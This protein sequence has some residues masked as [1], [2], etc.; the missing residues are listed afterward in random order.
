MGIRSFAVLDGPGALW[1]STGTAATTHPFTGFGG[2]EPGEASDFITFDPNLDV[3]GSLDGGLVPGD[4]T[5][6]VARDAGGQTN[7]WFS[8]GTGAGTH[9]IIGVLGANTN[10]GL[11]PSDLTVLPGTNFSNNSGVLFAGEDTNGKFNLWVTDGTVTGTH[12]LNVLA[13][14]AG[15]DPEYLTPTNT[16]L[17]PIPLFPTI[18][19]K[20]Y[21]AGID[22]TNTIGLWVTDGTASGTSLVTNFSADPEHLI[23]FDTA[24]AQTGRPSGEHLLA[25]QAVDTNGNTGLWVSDGTA[26][27]TTEVIGIPGAFSEG[28]FFGD[29]AP[30]GFARIN[31]FGNV[32][33]LLFDGKDNNGPNGQENLW[34]TDGTTATTHELT[35][36][37]GASPN[38]L[39]P[40]ELTTI[41]PAEV[42]FRGTDIDGNLGLWITN[43]TAGGTHE[44]TGI[45][46]AAS[47]FEPGNFVFLHNGETLFNGQMA[48]GG[49]ALWVTDGTVPGTHMVNVPG[50]PPSALT[51]EGFVSVTVPPPED[52]NGNGMSDL[53]LQ[54]TD[55]AAQMWLMNGISTASMTSLGNP[56]S[57]WHVA[58]TGDFNHNG[59]AD[60]IWQNTDGLTAIWLM[61][62]NSFLGST[63]L[64]N[65]GAS[66]HVIATGD[67]NSDGNADILWQNTDGLTAIWEM[68]GTSLVAAGPL[69]NPG[70]SWHAIGTGDFNGDGNADILWQNTDGLTAIWEMNGLSL[71]A[72]GPLGNPGASWHAIGT[73]DF[74]GDGNADILWQNTDGLTAIWEMNGFSLVAAGPLSN[75]GSAWHA[76]GTSDVN[77]DG[78][79]DIIWQNTDGLPAVWEMNGFSLIAAGPLPNLG[80]AWHVKD[81]GP[82]P[83]DQMAISG[84]ASSQAALNL[85]SPGTANA[86][87]SGAGLTAPLPSGVSPPLA[88]ALSSLLNSPT[89]QTFMRQLFSGTG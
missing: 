58:A 7:L 59:K 77:G 13:G 17:G 75:P 30:P 34:V 25:F 41:S 64:G 55:G 14:P 4:E 61:N 67:F 28:I 44:L 35:G 83:P 22:T 50:L 48:G 76:I 49:T 69:G 63:L 11:D 78:T 16:A 2:E 85:G 52:F 87:T 18:T 51:P 80:A 9:E 84:A 27:G 3:N 45:I 70:A 32:N 86:L 71:V 38:G 26:G 10:V 62:G 12:E 21:F 81:D 68:N 74:N 23:D 40:E 39:S 88:A 60:I 56:G 42:L 24:T 57:A 20:V 33:G 73:G 31:S 54:N 82:I 46:G 65:P 8:N 19:D 37:N 89:E 53:L 1:S 66:W 15:L 79:A 6:F 72:A 5:L 47:N 43:G 36:I 29:L